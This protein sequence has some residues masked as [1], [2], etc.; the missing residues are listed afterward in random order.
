MRRDDGSQG[1]V[2]TYTLKPDLAWGDGVPLTARDLVF[3]LKVSFAF[4]PSQF[5]E[6]AAAADDHHLALTLRTPVYDYQRIANVFVL[7]EHVEGPIF[8]AARDLIDYGDHSALNRHPEEKGLWFVPYRVERFELWRL[9]HRS[10]GHGVAGRAWRVKPRAASAE[11]GGGA[12][13]IRRRNA[14]Y[15]AVFRGFRR[16]H[17]EMAAKPEP[18]GSGWRHHRLDR[19]VAAEIAKCGPPA[20]TETAARSARWRPR[21]R[22]CRC[23]HGARSPRPGPVL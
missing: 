13:D 9:S 16:Y 18:A 11:M 6:S 5:I 3:S 10:V 15:S 17:T 7:P 8:A 12:G 14:V 22:E 4:S 21:G 19:G 1:M 2:V 23:R 20:P